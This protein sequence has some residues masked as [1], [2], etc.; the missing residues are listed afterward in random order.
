MP[1]IQNK[2]KKT[3]KPKRVSKSGQA[4]VY[5]HQHSHLQTGLFHITDFKEQ[6]EYDDLKE[7]SAIYG[8]CY[9]DTL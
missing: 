3:N 6:I 4:L 9:K 8:L 7:P 5:I 1:T 2:N